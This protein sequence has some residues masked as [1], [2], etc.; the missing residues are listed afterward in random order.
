MSSSFTYINDATNAVQ[1][2]L[3]MQYAAA[4]TT[5]HIVH[6][7]IGSPWPDITLQAAGPRSGTMSALLAT[8]DDANRLFAML[9]GTT[10]LVFSDDTA[11]STGMNFVANGTI[12]MTTDDQQRSYWVITTDYLEVQP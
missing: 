12:T 10:V 7:V 9:Q 2:L 11:V 8:E 1:P 3:V 4:S 6:D 5:R